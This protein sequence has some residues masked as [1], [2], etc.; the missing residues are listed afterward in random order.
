MGSLPQLFDGDCK[1]ARGFLDQLTNYFQ[2]NSHVA[3][4]NSPIQKVSITLT[5]FNGQEVVA[6]V[7]DMGAWI[8]SLDQVNDN[9]P[10]VWKVFTQE[11]NDHFSDSQQQQRACLEL[12][13]CRMRFP[14]VD[15]YISDFEDLVRQLG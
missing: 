14:D 2:A 11:F 9:I 4:L 6:W 12:N 1:L 13:K 5:L 10:E 15:Q 8:D 7:W 3:G